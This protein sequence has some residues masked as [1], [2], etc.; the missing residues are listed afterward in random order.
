MGIEHGEKPTGAEEPG[1]KTF[2]TELRRRRGLAGLS[3]TG[4]AALIH[5]SGGHISRVE[6]G[7]KRPS[8][9][10]ARACDQVL[11]AEDGLLALAAGPGQ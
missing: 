9:N 8:E 1:E 11:R 4:L 6:N 2:G 7:E 5:Y 3:L 10:F